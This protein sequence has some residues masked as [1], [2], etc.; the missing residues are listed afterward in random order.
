M[1][2]GSPPAGARVC[3]AADWAACAVGSSVKAP[4]SAAPKPRN[5]PRV[6]LAVTR[7][8][9]GPEPRPTARP[10]SLIGTHRASTG[11]VV[12]HHRA[13]TNGPTSGGLWYISATHYHVN[14]AQHGGSHGRNSVARRPCVARRHDLARRHDDRLRRPACHRQNEKAVRRSEATH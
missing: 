1:R 3:G 13:D 12:S 8:L 6:Y 9:Q 14:I 7:L 11:H 10:P 4:A 2:S 5:S